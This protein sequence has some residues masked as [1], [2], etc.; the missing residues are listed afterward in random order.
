MHEELHTFK[1]W[2]IFGSPCVYT[3][4]YA[5]V[6]KFNCTS[7]RTR[8]LH[9]ASLCTAVIIN[10]SNSYRLTMCLLFRL[11]SG[12]TRVGD[13]RGRQLRVSPLYFFL[14]NLAHRCHYHY[15]FL[16][17]SLRCHPSSVGCHLFT[18]PTSFLHFS[19]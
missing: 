4:S 6:W 11:C 13:T 16:L 15:R 17:L 7:C 1:M 12:V 5:M 19:L 8:W 10:K 9:D 2:S 14:K 3:S 18:C